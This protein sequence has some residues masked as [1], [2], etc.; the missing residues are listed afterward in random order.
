VTARG[1]RQFDRAISQLPTLLAELRASAGH[2]VAD[3]P[4][5]PSA[6]GIYLFSEGRRPVYVGQTRNLRRR[7]QQHTGLTRRENEASFAFNIAKREA[8]RAGVILGRGRPA[9]ET[10][11]AFAPHFDRA[12]AA[13]ATMRVRYIELEDPVT[14]TLFEI[15]ASLALNTREFN[16]WET[17]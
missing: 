11:P 16:S 6:P 5:I 17:H 8:A 10:N 14:R 13:V 7:L 15:Y 4:T 1:V 2:R 3:H 12:R 9:L